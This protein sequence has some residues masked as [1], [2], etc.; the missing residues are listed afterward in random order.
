MWQIRQVIISR[1]EPELGFGAITAVDFQRSIV[2]AFFQDASETRSYSLHNAPLKRF[3]LQVGDQFVDQEGS[4][5]TVDKV[6]QQEGLFKYFAVGKQFWEDSIR[7]Q[8]ADKGNCLA[9]LLMGQTSDYPTYELRREAWQLKSMSQRRQSIGFGGARVSPLAHQLYIASTVARRALP[10][11]IIADEVG[12]G[13]TIEAG[14]I[15]AT[16][17]SLGRADKVLIMAPESLVNQWVAELYRR[18]GEI[19]AILDQERCLQEEASQQLS[20][21]EACQ[22]VIVSHNFFSENPERFAQALTQA[23]DLVIIDEA[24]HLRWDD[25]EPNLLWQQ[26]QA[27]SFQCKGLLLLTATPLHYG[28]EGQFGLL[29]LLDPQRYA[30]CDE[31]CYETEKYTKIAEIAKLIKQEAEGPEHLALLEEL[32]ST[33]NLLCQH[34]RLKGFP[35]RILASYPLRAADHFYQTLASLS[36]DKVTESELLSIASGRLLQN[37]P[38]A[39]SVNSCR[40][41]W[42]LGLLAQL[43][44]QKVLVLC[45]TKEQVEELAR[46]LAT[47]APRVGNK[48][49]SYALFHE[50]LSILERDKQ[51]ARFV[52]DDGAQILIASEIG[53]EGRNFQCTRHLVL[54]D[55]PRAP[56]LLEQ[57]I[58][59]LDRI[60]QGKEITIH[61]PWIEESP[62]EALFTWYEQGLQAFASPWA[63]ANRV[64]EH[65]AEDLFAL[66][67]AYLPAS[68]LYTER[69]G[70]LSL[71]VKETQLK[72]AELRREGRRGEEFLLD[73][74]SFD[75]ERGMELLAEVEDCDDDTSVEFFMRNVFQHY[76]VDFEEYDDRGS[77]LIRGDSLMFLE[78]FPGIAEDKDTLLTFDR[79]Q[80]LAREDMLF[81]TCDHPLV[82]SSL[83]LL[84]ERNEGAASICQWDRSPLGRELLLE[85]SFVLEASGPRELEAS[86]Y[87]PIS[88]KEV[89]L[90]HR[91]AVPSRLDYQ[92]NSSLLREMRLSADSEIFESLATILPNLARKAHRE[93]EAWAEKL[94]AV[95]L[96]T[97]AQEHEQEFARLR[98][99]LEVNPAISPEELVYCEERYK[100]RVAAISQASVRLDGVRAIFC[101]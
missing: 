84:L 101:N 73:L 63:N 71:L 88:C 76:G 67:R 21:F 39:A 96:H 23:W 20:A 26:A 9:Q 35:R 72:A 45:A 87:L 79:Q 86:R 8:V 37:S 47:A 98:Y 89:V 32:F 54:M 99:L 78:K 48:P 60:G 50:K 27:L 57:R 15:F 70:L 25:E 13:K 61:V 19:F 22:R 30:D 92:E 94:R 10:R 16:L 64:L 34:L 95:A 69:K 24:H 4:V 75:E 68:K 65:C 55:I 12:L 28:V 90:T 36:V 14:L 62:E 80:A 66:F 3:V 40:Y 51:A 5:Y 1:S 82:E 52:A 41:E 97:L 2:D 46:F 33:D 74:N 59:R 49:I 77:L 56:D 81:L 93:A 6:E 53:G 31:Y 85:C 18:F 17:K 100:Q 11:A 38:L 58:G 42:F 83:G 29:N 7:P 43:G 44:Q 91:G